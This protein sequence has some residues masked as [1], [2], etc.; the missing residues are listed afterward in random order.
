MN[1][2]VYIYIFRHVSIWLYLSIYIY[3]WLNMP[4]S[5]Y[6]LSCLLS[7]VMEGHGRFSIQLAVVISIVRF[8]RF[9]CWDGS[10]ITGMDCPLHCRHVSR[11]EHQTFPWGCSKSWLAAFWSTPGGKVLDDCTAVCGSNMSLP[12]RVGRRV[13]G[14]SV[15]AQC[16]MEFPFCAGIPTL[17]GKWRN[18]S[19]HFDATW[20]DLKHWQIKSIERCL[21]RNM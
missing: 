20:V 21:S 15:A 2:Y 18:Q 6:F 8:L 13:G 3:R 19:F 4:S 12:A 10:W 14:L 5:S 16:T 9:W 17:A 11:L 1:I 7:G